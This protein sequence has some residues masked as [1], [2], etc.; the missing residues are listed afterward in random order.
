MKVYK[1]DLMNFGHTVYQENG[2]FTV[3]CDERTSQIEEILL[4]EILIEFGN[5]KITEIFESVCECCGSIDIEFQTN[6][7]WNIYKNESSK[8]VK[9]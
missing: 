4:R 7:P 3:V 1:S 2:M 9:H 8:I 6:L 5:Y